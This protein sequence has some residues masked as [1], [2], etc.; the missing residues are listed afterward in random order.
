MATNE[1]GCRLADIFLPNSPLNQTTPHKCHSPVPTMPCTWLHH[2]TVLPTGFPCTPS[3]GI[4][5]GRESALPTSVLPLTTFLYR[6]LEALEKHSVHTES[7][8]LHSTSTHIPSY[9]YVYT[10]LIRKS[11][12]TRGKH[13]TLIELGEYSREQA[14]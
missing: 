3:Q 11:L 9:T 13:V 5:T 6:R 10:D 1:W 4:A 14:N 7:V 2:K 12:S 8:A